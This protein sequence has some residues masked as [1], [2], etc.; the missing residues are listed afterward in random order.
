MSRIH[1]LEKRAKRTGWLWRSVAYRKQVL[2][3]LSVIPALEWR[4]P[5][6][7]GPWLP[8]WRGAPFL[9]PVRS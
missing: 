1:R 6:R 8:F 4:K 2:M 5:L 7:R 3:G 9:A